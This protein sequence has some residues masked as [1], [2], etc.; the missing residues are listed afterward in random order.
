M[1]SVV[2]DGGFIAILDPNAYHSF[3]DEDSTT[4]HILRGHLIAQ[5]QR[6]SILVWGTGLASEWR[7]NVVVGRSAAEGYREVTGPLRVADRYLCLSDYY[8]LFGAAM[9]ESVSLPPANQ[10]SLYIEVESGVYQ[11]RVVQMYNPDNYDGPTD[12][13]DFIIEL[14]ADTARLSPWSEIPWGFPGS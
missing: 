10:R 6:K 9:N 3:I 1:Y 13:Y 4:Y 5:M 2:D 8:T 11:C 12:D 7:V 14:S